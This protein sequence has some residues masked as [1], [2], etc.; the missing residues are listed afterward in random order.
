MAPIGHPS[1]Q[2]PRGTLEGDE[3][4]RTEL[5]SHPAA[6]ESVYS[7]ITHS[8]F[9][10]AHPTLGKILGGLAQ[11]PSTALDIGLSAAVP[12]LGMMVPGTTLNRGA[13]IIGA[14]NEVAQDETGRQKEAQTELERQQTAN[15]PESQELQR[16]RLTADL[17]EKGLRY[18]QEGKL[19]PIPEEELTPAQRVALNGDWKPVAGVAGPN[20]E[21]MEANDKTGMYRV[22]PGSGGSSVV[23]TDKTSGGVKGD[24][25]RKLVEA[26]NRGD[27]AAVAT[28]RQQL[29][30]IDP[31][32]ESRLSLDFTKFAQG[33]KDKARQYSRQDVRDHDKAYVQPAEGIEKSFDMMDQAY[34]EYKAAKAK[35]QDLPTGAQSMLA[36]STHLST[37]FG[38]VKG[39]RV[40]K[41]MIHEHLG[42]RSISDDAL[43]AFQRLTN[44]DQLSPAQWEAFHNLIGQSRNL[45]WQTAVKEAVR[46]GIPIDFL[47]KD[48]QH[49]SVNGVDYEMGDD[50][51][52]HQAEK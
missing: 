15:L 20:G 33:E 11:V 44:G 18:N 17:A 47:P 4:H 26:Y 1:I 43:V 34:N 24:L 49:K 48:L 7:R 21:P 22:A 46:K 8:D 37:T 25:Q 45:S 29:K 40:T 41:D 31:A 42:A 30:D 19:E 38:N 36:L 9:G 51:Q 12:R 39:A 28:Y 35:G 3:A 50:G 2:A 14:G 23:S 27:K 32:A 6:L 13:K 10:E 52:Y 5:E 16:Q